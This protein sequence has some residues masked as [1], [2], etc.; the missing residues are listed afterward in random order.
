[1]CSYTYHMHT[2]YHMYAHIYTQTYPHHTHELWTH[3]H[4][5][6]MDTYHTQPHTTHNAD[7]HVHHICSPTS[8]LPH[9]YIQHTNTSMYTHMPH[10]HTLTKCTHTTH[11]SYTYKLHTQIF[12]TPTYMHRHT[13]THIWRQREWMSGNLGIVCLH[14]GG[15]CARACMLEWEMFVWVS[16]LYVYGKCVHFVKVCVCGMSL[17]LS[18]SLSLSI[19]IY[20]Y[21]YIF[22]LNPGVDTYGSIYVVK[23]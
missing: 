12:P 14:I 23:V 8:Y 2:D 1:M 22:C 9:V 18:L 16:S 20:I 10:A 15:M 11:V 17:S 13:H 4:I 6:C 3:I 7:K 19:Y 5:T 21:I